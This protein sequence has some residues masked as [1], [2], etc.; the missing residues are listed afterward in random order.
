MTIQWFGNFFFKVESKEKIIAFF[1]FSEKDCGLKP[2]RFKADI[3]LTNQSEGKNDYPV[4][5]NPFIVEGPGEVEMG[6][7]FIEGIPDL[8]ENKKE[9]RKLNTIFF[10]SSE[11]ITL[12]HLGEIKEKKL[13]EEVLEKVG[14][15]DILLIPIGG[16]NSINYEEAIFIANQ[17]EPKILI[18]MNYALPQLRIKLEPVEKFI[19]AVGG[20]VETINKLTIKK[21]NLSA[22]ER[23]VIILNKQ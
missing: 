20:K 2:S 16:N 17:I 9:G 22:E 18:P 12:C 5:G 10:V 14:G 21:N 11:N 8:A 13:K 3:L 1:P 19:K 23:K 4:F 6:G 7:I 15:V